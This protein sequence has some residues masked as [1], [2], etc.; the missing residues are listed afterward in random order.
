M[1]TVTDVGQWLA[2][3]G[4]VFYSVKEKG[5]SQRERRVTEQEFNRRMEIETQMAEDRERAAT[6]KQRE[7]ERNNPARRKREI[8]VGSVVR[9]PATGPRRVGGV[10]SSSARNGNGN[11]RGSGTSGSVVRRPMVPRKPGRAF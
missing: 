7:A 2:E 9:R 8:E 3:L 10:V 1:K 11:G 5:Y 4:G 6:E